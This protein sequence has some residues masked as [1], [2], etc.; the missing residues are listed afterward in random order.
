MSIIFQIAAYVILIVGVFAVINKFYP[1]FK[2]WITNGKVNYLWLVLITIGIFI[3]L[4]YPYFFNLWAV[5]FWHVPE[6]ELT[7]FTKLGP[8]GDIYGS[9]N[10]LFTSATLAIVI[11]STILQRQANEDTRKAMYKELIQAKSLSSLQLKQAKQ[12][13][14]EQLNLVKETH[15]AQIKESQYTF[16]TNQF[17]S[18]L[19]LKENKFHKLKI[20]LKAGHF[21]QDQIF[22]K[23]QIQFNR[24]LEGVENE[25]ITSD[26]LRQEFVEYIEAVDGSASDIVLSY[27]LIYGN[28]IKLIK[29]SSL[30]HDEKQ[31]Y[32]EILGNSMRLQEQVVFFWVSS[33]AMRF[34]YQLDYTYIFNQ[35]YNDKYLI[36][37]KKFHRKSA[38]P[39]NWHSKIDEFNL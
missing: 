16:F 37:A 39:M 5:Y 22:I 20:K 38:F 17:Y 24:I 23:L 2:D 13:S 19:N 36:V 31:F 1:N 14:A 29:S 8:L 6:S 30:S 34:N 35:F 15:N 28:L 33:F 27:F 21:E 11:Y 12:A 26:Y 10:T 3:F 4:T 7:D 9:L 18:L 25:E 32:F